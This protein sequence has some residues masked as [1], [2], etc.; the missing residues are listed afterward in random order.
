MSC[1]QTY[2]FVCRY[3]VRY[4]VPTNKL[5]LY[6]Q[7]DRDLSLYRY[8]QVFTLPKLQTTVHFDEVMVMLAFFQTIE[9]IFVD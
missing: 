2:S 6:S 3:T 4:S 7:N 5:H 9:S 8:I 1:S